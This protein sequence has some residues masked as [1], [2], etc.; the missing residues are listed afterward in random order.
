RLGVF[1]MQRFGEPSG[2]PTVTLTEAETFDIDLLA[3]G[4]EGRGV[5]AW[6]VTVR[7]G[8]NWYPMDRDNIDVATS[9]AFKAFA[10][11]EWRTAVAEDSSVKAINRLASDLTFETYL[12]EEADAEAE[13]TRLLALHSVGR[14]RFQVSVKSFLVD[15]VELGSVVRLVHR[16]FGLAAGK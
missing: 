1:R 11:T 15:R 3:T 14:D 2:F 13:A 5:P 9:E 8:R 6:R 10:T 7:Y 16:R 4:D 12:T